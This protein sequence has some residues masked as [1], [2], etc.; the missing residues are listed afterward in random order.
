MTVQWDLVIMY[1][2]WWS[3]QLAFNAIKVIKINSKDTFYIDKTSH[4][5]LY[6][7]LNNTDC[8]I[9]ALQF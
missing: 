3:R 6:S 4:L 9:A 2:N 1:F 8:V 7:T 5:Y